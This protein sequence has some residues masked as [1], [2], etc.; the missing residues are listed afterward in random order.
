MTQHTN[1]KFVKFDLNSSAQ[2]GVLAAIIVLALALRLY[3][4][5]AWS[6]WGDEIF[7]I[8][9]AQATFDSIGTIF[10]DL[11]RT[12]RYW[13]ALSIILTGSVLNILGISEWS[14]RLVPA[15]IGVIS[16]PILYFPIRKL[17]GVSVALV[18]VLLL[19]ISPWHLYWSQNARFYTALLLFY[20][21]ALFVFYFGIEFD[22]PWYILL[23]MVLLVIAIRE[24]LFALILV[25]VVTSYLVLLKILPFE[26]PPGLRLRNLVLFFLPGMIAALYFII[27]MLRPRYLSQLADAFGRINNNPLWLLAGVVYYVGLPTICLGALGGLYLLLKKNRASLLLSLGALIP[28]LTIM[29]LSPFVYTANRYVFLSL[30]SWLILASVAAKELLF[31]TRGSAKILAFGALIILLAGPLSEDMLYYRYQNGN[32]DNWRAAFELIKQHKKAGD[33]VVAAGPQLG[34]YYLQEKTIGMENLD[35]AQ[36]EENGDRVW[37]V[38]DMNVEERWPHIHTWLEK[39]AQLITN[40]DVHVRARNFKMRVYLY[41]PAQHGDSQVSATSPAALESTGD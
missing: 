29:A 2:Y 9:R 12:I 37:F 21:L 31:Q 11:G 30:V 24:R 3:K 33:L 22:R 36:F 15:I 32:R 18:A 19:T 40:L 7:N 27:P 26:K 17:F 34:N 6:F 25:P 35:L 10:N 14:A 41:D 13:P 8:N 28:L 16:V 38:E 1:S 5:G 20:T 39:N 4:L 23:S